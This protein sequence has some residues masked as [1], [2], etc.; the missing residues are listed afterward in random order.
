MRLGA[1]QQRTW[2]RHCLR[3]AGP[4]QCLDAWPAGI[5]QAQDLGGLV[6]R[7]SR[8]IVDRRRKP[9]ILAHAIDAQDLAMPARD[10]QQQIGK[11]E[12]RIGEA[13]RE[14][15][16]LQMVDRDQRLARCHRQC[17]GGDEP[18][19]HPADQTRP[20]GRGDRVDIVQHQPRVLER[21]LDQRGQHLHMR[22]RRDFGHHA[23]IGLVRLFLP[24]QP[25]RQ[26]GPVRPDQRR[27]ALVAARFDAQDDCHKA[28]PYRHTP[29]AQEHGG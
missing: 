1:A 18:H 11:F 16:A 17:L 29:L 7:L 28:S 23:A 22:A 10:E 6:E 8:R 21:R 20:G 26:H 3:I 12:A 2:Q 13:R 15:M 9:A 19:H 5:A 14:R 4:C 27:R 25:V 24:R